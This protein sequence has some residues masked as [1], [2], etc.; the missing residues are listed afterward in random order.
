MSYQ[1]VTNRWVPEIKRLNDQLEKL[2]DSLAGTDDCVIDIF[3]LEEKLE[4]KMTYMEEDLASVKECS[5]DL[6]DHLNTIIKELYTITNG[7]IETK[8]ES[9]EEE[10]MSVKVQNI[11][12]RNH[13][14]SFIKQL[15]SVT[16]LI[17]KKY[18]DLV[19]QTYELDSPLK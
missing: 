10:I 7:G 16:T 18:G 9:L 4:N 3:N 19:E 14:N 12:L 13:L 8:L 6:K 11:E 1:A 5:T 15:N 17:N 2:Q